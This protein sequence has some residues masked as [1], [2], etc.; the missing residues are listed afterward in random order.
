[1]GEIVGPDASIAERALAW[2]KSNDGG[3]IF[4]KGD[5]RQFNVSWDHGGYHEIG[6]VYEGKTAVAD[7]ELICDV[8][9]W[10]LDQLVPSTRSFYGE[11]Y[12]EADND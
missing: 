10:A 9:N 3:R 4:P 11:R 2:C 8:F 12:Y 6:W 7:I 5:T 1:V